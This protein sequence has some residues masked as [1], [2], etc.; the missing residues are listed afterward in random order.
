[1]KQNPERLAWTVLLA[2]FASFCVVA[3]GLPAAIRSYLINDRQRLHAQV[4]AQRGTVRVERAGSNRGSATSLDDPMPLELF[5]GDVVRTG[6]LDE[7]LLTVQRPADES[8]ETLISVVIYAN[9]DIE[10]EDAYSPRFGLSSG[11]HK[12]NLRVVGGRVRIEVQP[13]S[14]GRPVQID[15]RTDRARIGLSEGSYAVDIT[16]HQTTAT[17]RRGMASIRAGGQ[18]LELTDEQS[19]SVTQSGQLDGPLPAE[20]NLIVNGDFNQGVDSAWVAI[21]N[22]PESSASVSNATAEEGQTVALFDHVVPRP[23]EAGLIQTLN[24]NVKDL[25]S[26]VLHLKVR[27]DYQSLSVCGSQGSE[28]PVMVRID[29]IDAA[30]GDRQWVHGF[31]G[32]E[33]P[34]QA[35][36][37]PYYCLTCPEPSSGNHNQVPGRSWFLYDSPNLMEIN[38]PELR[39]AVIQSVRVYASGHSYNSMVTGIELLAQE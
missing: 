19:A 23:A 25:T 3:V 35:G 24:R 14:D 29:Y 34:A 2:A 6:A 33:D 30:G 37:L 13:S 26:L 15:V 7:G 5:K 32:F 36:A 22:P 38:P 20:R 12:A 21:S 31:Y 16:N 27:V 17:V 18:E 4:N 1:M 11:P 10:L 9:S 39:P 28:C 8:R